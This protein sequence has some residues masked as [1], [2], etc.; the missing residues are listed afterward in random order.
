MNLQEPFRT[1]QIDF[2]KIVYTKIKTSDKKKIIY[3]KYNDNKINK[4]LVIQLPSIL[5][6][7]QPVK[8]N[9]EYY[10][11]EIPLI[12]Q[13]KDK[14]DNLIN[15]LEY[16]DKKIIQ[17]AKDNS[18]IWLE[19]FSANNSIKYKK[20]IRESDLYKEGVIKIKIIKNNDFET[21]LQVD[22][23]KRITIKEI[24]S[25]S[26][27]KMLIEIYALVINAQTN[28]FSIFARPIILSFKDKQVNNYNYTFLE[29]SDSDSDKEGNDI[30]DTEL[31]SIFLK[32]LSSNKKEDMLTSSQIKVIA[33][34]NKTILTSSSEYS[35]TSS[36]KKENVKLIKKDLEGHSGWEN[37]NEL[38]KLIN[39][40]QNYMILRDFYD[41]K[42]ENYNI[43]DI[44]FLT[45]DY[46]NLASL[47]N[48]KQTTDRPYKGT[49]SVKQK[50]IKVDIRHISDNYFDAVTISF[51]VRNFQNLTKGL[52]EIKRVE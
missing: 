27:C 17:D 28:T 51:G 37:Y 50:S 34:N 32:T 44:D 7:N 38:F 6:L 47:M 11:L 39:Y 13:D 20:I 4:P 42:N 15:F 14:S 49:I 35:S 8:I 41:F 9:E 24:P 25:N 2:N 45:D 1:H 30:P 10:E 48:V 3:I 29:D 19:G 26:W 12:T 22:N 5:N 36:P 31:N 21:L 16:L 40:T 23:K 33:E 46:Q 18:K 43:G 52:E